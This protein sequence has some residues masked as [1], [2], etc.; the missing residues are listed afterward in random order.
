MTNKEQQ[1]IIRENE[2]FISYS[3]LDGD[4]VTSLVQAFAKH[5]V[6]PWFDTD[7]IPKGAEWWREIQKGIVGANTFVFIIS[8]DSIKSMVCNWELNYAIS[9]NKRIIPVLYSDIWSNKTAFQDLMNEVDGL[10][11]GNPDGRMVS[12]R[13]NWTALQAINFIRYRT[14]DSSDEFIIELIK[15]ARTDLSYLEEHTR[16]LRRAVD[17]ESAQDGSRLLRGKELAAAEAWLH[18]SQ[19]N[20]PAPSTLHSQ[21]VVASR[22]SAILRG[23]IIRSSIISSLIIFIIL[24]SIGISETNAR[25]EQQRIAE[26][27]ASLSHSMDLASAA[28]QALTEGNLDLALVLA[29]EANQVNF[30][31]IEALRILVELS[32][33]PGTIALLAGHT[34]GVTDL[35]FSPDG[36]RLVSGGED[37]TIRLWNVVSGREEMVIGGHTDEVTSVM[38]HPSGLAILS[39]SLDGTM[40]IWDVGTGEEIQRFEHLQGVTDVAYSTD[41]RIAVAGLQPETG[42]IEGSVQVWE[43]RSESQLGTLRGQYG[44]ITSIRF[45]DRVNALIGSNAPS[46][47]LCLW[48]V[49]QDEPTR[50]YDHT[51]YEGR[52][53][54]GVSDIAVAPDH[55]YFVWKSSAGGPN[56]DYLIRLVD[57]ETGAEREHFGEGTN[58]Q[59]AVIF[60]LDGQTVLSNTS[61]NTLLLWDI[62]SGNQIRSLEGHTGNITRIAIAPDGRLAATASRDATIRI[63]DLFPP[64]SEVNRFGEPGLTNVGVELQAAFTMNDTQIV[65][66]AGFEFPGNFH[67]WDMEGSLLQESSYPGPVFSMAISPDGRQILIGSSGHIGL[68]DVT[69]RK[70]LRRF[71]EYSNTRV[72]GVAFS[73]D[74]QMA[75]SGSADSTIRLWDVATGEEIRH[76]EGHTNAVTS[77]AF[78]PEGRLVVSGSQDNTIRLWDVE[79]AIELRRLEGHSATVN[80][81]AFSPDGTLIASGSGESFSI[82][83]NSVRLWIT[84][85]G[86]EIQHFGGFTTP[87]NRVV[88]SPDGQNIMFGLGNPGLWTE[89][90]DNTVRIW[91]INEGAEV[92]RFEGHI[93]GVF[94]VAF[95]SDGRLALSGSDDGTARLW[96]VADSREVMIAWLLD[97]RYLRDL[98]C[99]ERAQYSIEPFCTLTDSFSENSKFFTDY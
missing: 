12:A 1:H 39:G 24:I 19:N 58:V 56:G 36:S 89:Q 62:S 73:P 69:S 41:G 85:T 97:N 17:W 29:R 50:C 14:L 63:W 46:N 82:A 92:Q 34:A 98:T 99:T 13:Q 40:R 18:K 10:E 42:S 90:E 23:R 49:Y 70:L 96:K 84:E 43:I 25:M 33:D 52:M 83:D 76:F 31:S 7:D 28:Q 65:S 32:H 95:S 45:V 78:D 57:L 68:L 93:A 79:E 80:S 44:E 61:S 16:L 38:F 53:I 8:Y 74:G 75:V 48:N 55:R 64:S 5:N 77:V 11:W 67:L 21:Y 59:G 15:I 47:N 81:V 71:E 4:F 35:D 26:R 60:S 20:S 54:N 88:F 27:E 37:R 6:D 9:Q 91:S 66:G 87:V 2:I 94:S 30:P 51:Y 86:Q 72:H 22:K 3:R